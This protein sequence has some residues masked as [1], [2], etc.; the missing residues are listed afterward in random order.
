ML[1][2]YAKREWSTILAIGAMIT[3]TLIVIELPLLGVATLVITIALLS[4]FRDPHRRPPTVRNVM[5]AP[6]DG[7]ISSIHRVDN[8]ELF[9]EPAIC[10][11]IFLS[12]LD[13]HINRSPCHGIVQSITH[14]PGD[15]L[16]ALNPDSAE[17]NESVTMLLVH[18]TR[19]EQPVAAVRQVAGLLARTI[20]NA[21]RPQVVL[22]R[23]QRF[24]IIKLGSTTELYI[25]E[26]AQPTI[27]VE[28]GQYVYAGITVLAQL[29]PHLPYTDNA[30]IT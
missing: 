30:P 2:G 25:P 9:N 26:S 13:V 8:Y 11:R 23:G 21:A 14:Q 22:Q 3:I 27:N 19:V 15:H 6:A 20:V 5:T 10:V 24:G 12:V 28:Q 16:N 17:A 29:G 18:P 4:F 1:S 7:R